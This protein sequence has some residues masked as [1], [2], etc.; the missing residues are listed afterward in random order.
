MKMLY[1]CYF[2]IDFVD[3]GYA[4]NWISNPW[5]YKVSVTHFGYIYYPLYHFLGEDMVLLR[6]VN[7]LII[8]VLS[9]LL[10]SRTLKYIVDVED[11]ISNFS[12]YYLFAMAFII[13]TCVFIFF[14][15][16]FTT[17]QL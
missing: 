15:D 11:F 16:F 8:L 6:Q 13:A 14:G 10:C 1:R 5:L 7:M 4:L 17:P 12:I 9:Y 3:E 2:G